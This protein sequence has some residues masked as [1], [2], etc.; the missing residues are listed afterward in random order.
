M[1]IHKSGLHKEVAVIFGGKPTDTDSQNTENQNG[2]NQ[3]DAIV[4]E[5]SQTDCQAQTPIEDDK[6]KESTPKQIGYVPELEQLEEEDD[7]EAT[8]EFNELLSEKTEK[9]EEKQIDDILIENDKSQSNTQD[10][11]EKLN[12]KLHSYTPKEIATAVMVVVLA[13]AFIVILGNAFGLF[14]KK[15]NTATEAAGTNDN[16]N[17]IITATKNKVVDWEKPAL[18]PKTMR[19]PMVLGSTM[20]LSSGDLTVKGIL[21]SSDSPSVLIGTRIYREGDSIDEIIIV[22]I[23]KDSVDFKKGTEKWN[24]KVK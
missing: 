9:I 20:V 10:F 13:G 12:E 6:P 1:E 22:K 7:D 18:Y 16:N 19:N 15:V 11:I 5:P 17:T 24:Q 2:E 4:I 8:S 14:D 3:N 21:F 23:H